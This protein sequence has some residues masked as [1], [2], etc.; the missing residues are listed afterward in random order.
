M[1]RPEFTAGAGIPV[2]RPTAGPAVSRDA[3]AE[4]PQFA[5]GVPSWD[6]PLPPKPEKYVTDR[7][8]ILGSERVGALSS[9]LEQLDHETSNQILVWVDRRIPENF[10]LEDFALRAFNKWGVGQA[11]INNG[12]VLFVFVDD[13]KLRI[14]VGAGLQGS[15]PDATAKR[16]ID[17][18]IVP[19]FRSNDYAAGVEAGVTA[20]IAATKGEYRSLASVN[21]KGSW[22]GTVR[23]PGYPSYSV[24]MTITAAKPGEPAGTVTYPE[25][26]CSGTLRCEGINGTS[27]TLR[28]KILENRDGRCVD[29]VKIVMTVES[30]QSTTAA[31]AYFMPNGN[32]A[33][34]AELSRIDAQ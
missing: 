10:T 3:Q 4:Q 26:N 7:V 32:P 13:R 17:E 2:A 9:K 24:E 1:E 5:A 18:E 20:M 6:E 8:G 31:I 22:T 30:P 28:E 33:G 12:A 34:T 29:G 19:R 23:Q 16:I 15:L 25:L 27:I 21:T 11:Q 14:E